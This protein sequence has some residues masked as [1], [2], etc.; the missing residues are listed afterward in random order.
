MISSVQEIQILKK[1]SRQIKY[2]YTIVYYKHPFICFWQLLLPSHL[3]LSVVSSPCLNNLN[4]CK[5]LL[6]KNNYIRIRFIIDF[7]TYYQRFAMIQRGG[8]LLLMLKSYKLL[9]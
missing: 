1:S 5:I 7:N 8:E 6:F 2:I 9:M 3:F 4:V